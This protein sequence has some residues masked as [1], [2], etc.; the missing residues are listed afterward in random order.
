MNR[1]FKAL[2]FV[3][4]CV[5][6]IPTGVA[7]Q[8]AQALDEVL[9]EGEAVI[10][11]FDCETGERLS[12]VGAES[13]EVDLQLSKNCKKLRKFEGGWTCVGSCSKGEKCQPNYYNS[14]DAYSGIKS[15]SCQDI[16]Y[17]KIGRS[18]NIEF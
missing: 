13:G 3:G 5:F 17:P 7:A 12:V 18:T 11:V 14:K 1:I 6:V 9:D 15:C 4:A 16:T 8:S 10:E 2:F